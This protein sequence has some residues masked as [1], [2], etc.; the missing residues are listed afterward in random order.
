MKSSGRFK[1]VF[2]LMIV[3]MLGVGR[4]NTVLASRINTDSDEKISV[5]SIFPDVE[6][7]RDPLNIS[8]TIGEYVIR[9]GTEGAKS[10]SDIFEK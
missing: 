4:V 6:M 10:I 8:I 7:D 1:V 3:L 9:I 2:L 5:M